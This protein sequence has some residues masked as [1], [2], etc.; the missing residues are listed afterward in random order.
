MPTGWYT[1]RREE[2]TY[3]L[4]HANR[5]GRMAVEWLSRETARTGNLFD[6]RPTVRKNESANSSLTVGVQK[7]GRPINSPA[8]SS[9]G[10]HVPVKKSTTSTVNQ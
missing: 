2:N 6:T 1:R 5:Y 9:T 7:S 4:E 8:V 3:R 10:V